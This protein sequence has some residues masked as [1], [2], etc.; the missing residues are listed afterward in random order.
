[1]KTNETFDNAD[2]KGEQFT[3]GCTKLIIDNHSHFNKGATQC[4]HEAPV[5][6]GEPFSML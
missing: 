4:T 6:M 1:M 3:N 2:F 5:T